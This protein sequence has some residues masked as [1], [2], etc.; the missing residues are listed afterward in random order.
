MDIYKLRTC[1]LVTNFY[2]HTEGAMI[3][4]Q[5]ENKNNVLNLNRSVL[6]AELV[7][8]GSLD[9]D[10][11]QEYIADYSLSQWDALN[12]AIRFELTKD[13]QKEMDNSDL[14][15]AIANITKPHNEQRDSY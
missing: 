13:V 3:Y 9:E 10:S 1:M 15:K 5:R 2:S 8:I 7:A 14:F 11:D 4:Y 6:N 12:I